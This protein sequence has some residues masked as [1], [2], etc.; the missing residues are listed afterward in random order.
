MKAQDVIKLAKIFDKFVELGD[1][2]VLIE[3]CKI[4]IKAIKKSY[5]P[6]VGGEAFKSD[7]IEL[8]TPYGTYHDSI[9]FDT[10]KERIQDALEILKTQEHISKETTRKEPPVQSKRKVH[11]INPPAPLRLQEFG[12]DGPGSTPDELMER[13]TSLTLRQDGFEGTLFDDPNLRVVKRDQIEVL[14]PSGN[15]LAVVSPGG[16][17]EKGESISGIIYENG[18]CRIA[19]KNCPYPQIVVKYFVQRKK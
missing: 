14:D 19:A 4:N 3:D 11:P 18:K 2:L 15:Q 6:S 1:S 5:P 10:F 12:G 17:I 16:Q 8:V 13:T 7:G 9:D